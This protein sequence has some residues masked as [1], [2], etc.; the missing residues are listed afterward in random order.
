MFDLNKAISPYKNYC[1]GYGNSGTLDNSYLVGLIFGIGKTKKELYHEG[2][3]I[4]DNINA[5]DRAEVENAYLGQINMVTVSSFCG[6]MGGLIGYD[7]LK[8]KNI[9]KFHKYFPEGEIVGSDSKK[10]PVYT[11]ST[12]VEAT[13]SLFGTVNDKRF[14]LA[15]G[16]VVPCA[17]KH[18]SKKG[19]KHIY[20]GFG[21]GIAKNHKRDAHLF[22]EDIGD[23]PLYI[24][25]TEVE[26]LYRHKILENLAKSVLRI[27]ENQ[28]VSYKEIFVEM[29]DVMIQ[30]DEIGCSLVAAP[31]ITL[32]QNAIPEKGID[33]LFDISLESWKKEMDKKEF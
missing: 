22:M 19:P 17:G 28:K 6:P 24:K 31:Y 23:I 8:P 9:Y 32:A 3:S 15:P 33:T 18:I 21:L 30:P 10:I 2:T 4:L 25:G 20:C 29:H 26:G 14:P 11:A 7:I 27:G 1:N 5:F 13:K 16:S 12:L